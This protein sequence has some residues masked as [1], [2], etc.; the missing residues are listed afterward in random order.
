MVTG[1]HPLTAQAI[2]K[3]VGIFTGETVEDKAERLNVDIN[4]V[5]PR[6]PIKSLI[7]NLWLFWLNFIV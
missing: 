6:F 1:D 7:I 4:D 5:D 2:A 3:S